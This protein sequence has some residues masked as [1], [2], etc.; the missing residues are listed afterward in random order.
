MHPARD[1][2]AVVHGTVDHL[3]RQDSGPV[4]EPG[5]GPKGRVPRRPVHGALREQRQRAVGRHATGRTPTDACQGPENGPITVHASTP[6][7]EPRHRPVAA[8]NDDLTRVEENEE[9]EPQEDGLLERDLPLQYGSLREPLALPEKLKDV[10]ARVDRLTLR[11]VAG[12]HE[13]EVEEDEARHPPADTVGPED[14][15]DCQDPVDGRTYE[16]RF[17]V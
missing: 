15:D 12:G 4:Q 5:E 14:W 2:V 6:N 8:P 9:V 3:Y 16:S 17:G 7:S 1:V 10:D 11:Q 13:R